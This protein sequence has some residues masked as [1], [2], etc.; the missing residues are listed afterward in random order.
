MSYTVRP[1]LANTRSNILEHRTEYLNLRNDAEEFMWPT[2]I[3]LRT[4]IHTLAPL[5]C[6][7]ANL[8][9]PSST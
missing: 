1:Q 5:A 7:Q 6:L 2:Y 8:K 3:V 9:Q 4:L